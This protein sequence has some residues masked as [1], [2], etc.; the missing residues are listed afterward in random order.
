MSIRSDQAIARIC[1]LVLRER[2]RFPK[3]DL[4]AAYIDLGSALR[5]LIE[6]RRERCP[7][8]A[9]LEARIAELEQERES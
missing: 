5:D 2:I 9:R 7:T 6:E 3:G 8:C 4:A 1:E